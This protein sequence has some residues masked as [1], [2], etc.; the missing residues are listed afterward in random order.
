MLF[1]QTFGREYYWAALARESCC[2]RHHVAEKMREEQHASVG[3]GHKGSE[4]RRGKLLA[5]KE[6]SR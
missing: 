4:E 6:K 2:K 5:T 3:S 1:K